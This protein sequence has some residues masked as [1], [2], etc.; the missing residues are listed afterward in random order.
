[1]WIKQW[2][3]GGGGGYFCC[4]QKE[5]FH[6]MLSCILHYIKHILLLNI[7]TIGLDTS[8]FNLQ[9]SCQYFTIDFHTKYILLRPHFNNNSTIS[10][11]SKSL[12]IQA[13]MQ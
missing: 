8:Y 13:C 10:T 2:G 6:T 5:M 4:H 9:G 1:M 3:G 7:L 11:T 12:S